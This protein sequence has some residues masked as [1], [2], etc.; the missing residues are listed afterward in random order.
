MFKNLKIGTRLGLGFGLVLL[1]LVVISATALLR[2]TNLASATGLIVDDRLPKIEM[3]NEVQENT[4]NIGRAIRNVILATDVNFEKGQLEIIVQL[5][6]HN[7]EI[8][9]RLRPSITHPKGKELFE[10]VVTA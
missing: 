8:L 4:L 10:Q 2:I 6:K 3:I 7:E 5:R 1:L 9:D